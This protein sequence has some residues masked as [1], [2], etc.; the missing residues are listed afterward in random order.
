MV[1]IHPTIHFSFVLLSSPT[2]GGTSKNLLALKSAEVLRQVYPFDGL[3][4]GS[5]LTERLRRMVSS[6]QMDAIH[7]V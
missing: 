3:W 2:N 4:T 5:E 7:L 1:S 6:F